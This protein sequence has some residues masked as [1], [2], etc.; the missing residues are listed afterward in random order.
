MKSRTTLIE[1]QELAHLRR[2]RNGAKLWPVCTSAGLI[3]KSARKRTI[4]TSIRAITAEISDLRL[5]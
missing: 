1:F 3:G 2:L 5:L 4:R